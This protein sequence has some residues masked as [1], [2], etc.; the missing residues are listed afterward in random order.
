[1]GFILWCGVSLALCGAWR[2]FTSLVVL[3]VVDPDDAGSVPPMAGHTMTLVDATKVFILGGFSPTN[4][5]SDKVYK[6]DASNNQWQ[7]IAMTG[8]QPTGKV[9]YRVTCKVASS[10]IGSYLEGHVQGHR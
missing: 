5:Y 9:T 3:Q 7:E 4:Y 6:Y 1:M 2:L 10:F 8:A